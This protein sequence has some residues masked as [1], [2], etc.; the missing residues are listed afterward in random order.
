MEPRAREHLEEATVLAEEYL[1]ACSRCYLCVAGCTSYQA[2]RSP[3]HTPPRRLQAAAR[4][5]LENRAGQEDLEALY[6]CSMCGACTALC[7]YGIETWRVVHA[8]RMKLSLQGRQPASLQA[9]AENMVRSGHSFTPDP[10]GPRKVMAEAAAKA[11]VNPD[12]PA[13]LL[14]VPSPFETTLYPHVLTASLEALRRAGYEVTVSLQVLD[15]G[16]NA[17][18]DAA[19]PD[20][21]LEAAA[22]AY[23]RM[24]ELGARRLV[25]SGCGA[26]H[27]L[28][29]L[30]GHDDRVVSLYSLLEAGGVRSAGCENCILFPSCG[31]ARF[32]REEYPTVKRLGGAREPRDRPPYTLC[33]GGGGGVNYLREEP[34]RSLRSRIYAWRVK[35]L[36][37]GHLSEKRLTIVTPCIKC[38]TV[39]RHGVLAAGLRG[40][41]RVEHLSLTVQRRA[42]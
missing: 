33:C 26:D 1:E 31:F 7:P 24:E 34:F 28:A 37:G 5:L 4:V 10:S 36:A 23:E 18:F 21:G 2:L 20:V 39:L 13:E 19:R 38:Y 30:A 35:R 3:R 8:A 14:Y 11:G 12:E 15:Y 42:R 41:V 25:L 22:R 27:K 6:T 9:I 17:A 32:E 29:A 40:R 16:G